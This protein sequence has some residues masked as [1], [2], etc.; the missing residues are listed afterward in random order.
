VLGICDV[1]SFLLCDMTRHHEIYANVYPEYAV[2]ITCTCAVYL[3]GRGNR[4]AT[5]QARKD[6]ESS[7]VIDRT[8]DTPQ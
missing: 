4:L 6:V 8:E 1:G 2:S 7:G 5:D 3:H